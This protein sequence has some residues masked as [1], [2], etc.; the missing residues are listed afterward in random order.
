MIAKPGC[1][2]QTKTKVCP[3]K[4][5]KE[6]EPF[7]RVKISHAKFPEELMEKKAKKK[8]KRVSRIRSSGK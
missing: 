4:I 6:S 7:K 8:K 2:V 3:L 5:E 1:C